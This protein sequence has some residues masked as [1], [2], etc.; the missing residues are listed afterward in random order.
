MMEN[1]AQNDT[2]IKKLLHEKNVAD[3]IFILNLSVKKKRQIMTKLRKQ[4]EIFNQKILIN[5]MNWM[6][7]GQF[8][9][10]NF[11][12]TDNKKKFREY[13]VSETRKNQLGIVEYI[14]KMNSQ[15]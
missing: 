14:V 13:L 12:S 10:L 11:I 6:S 7:I 9:L 2:T 1:L 3:A 15:K 5:S 4:P 8:A